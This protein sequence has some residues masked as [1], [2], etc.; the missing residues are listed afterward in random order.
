MPSSCLDRASKV[1]EIHIR[2]FLYLF[3]TLCLVS[4]ISN[5]LRI[6]TESIFRSISRMRL[7]CCTPSPTMSSSMPSG[8]FLSTGLLARRCA[9]S[10]FLCSASI[11][12]LASAFNCASRCAVACCIESVKSA[13]APFDRSSIGL[14][15]PRL[16]VEE[17]AF[18]WDMLR[19]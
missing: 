4:D 15:C 2:I 19:Y 9:C 7:Y 5:L 14:L 16:E 10:F 12:S 8:I 18:G 11:L 17:G 1:L 3:E 13:T 6:I